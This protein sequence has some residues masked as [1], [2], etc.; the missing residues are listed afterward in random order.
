MGFLNRESSGEEKLTAARCGI[1]RM[2]I[3]KRRFIKNID[4]KIWVKL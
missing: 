1:T 2:N 4:L 3:I